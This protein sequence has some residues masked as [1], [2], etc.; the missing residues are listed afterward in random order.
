M[1]AGND[2][3]VPLLFYNYKENMN[4]TMKTQRVKKQLLAVSEDQYH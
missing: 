2:H 3:E 1:R 4:L